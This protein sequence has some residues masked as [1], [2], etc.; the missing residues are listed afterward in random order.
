MNIQLKEKND[1]YIGV[2]FLFNKITR[3]AEHIEFT[4][5]LL[6]KEVY[7]KKAKNKLQRKLKNLLQN[8]PEL[9]GLSTVTELPSTQKASPSSHLENNM[10]F[11]RIRGNKIYFDFYYTDS[12]T[13]KR[14][15]C[16]NSTGFKNSREN[17]IKAQQLALEK[18]AALLQPNNPVPQNQQKI[19]SEKPKLIVSK[20][21]K[22]TGK[23][24]AEFVEYYLTTA[25]YHRLAKKSKQLYEMF[26][27]LYVLPEFGEIPL[28]LIDSDL[29][30][31]FELCLIDLE[32]SPKFIRDLLSFVR[33]L[34]RFA[35]KRKML[36]FCPQFDIISRV[37]ERKIKYLNDEQ[38]D[39]FVQHVQEQENHYFPILFFTLLT[40]VRMGEAR[41]VQWGDLTLEGATPKVKIQRS[42]DVDDTFKSTKTNCTREI[43][44][45]PNLVQVL[46]EL[47]QK[48]I[49]KGKE[50]IVF[51]SVNGKS[52]S[53]TTLHKVVVRAAK[54]IGVEKFSFHGLRHTFATHVTNQYGV[55]QASRMLGHSDIKTTMIYYQQDIRELSKIVEGL[56]IKIK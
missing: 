16:Q 41:S 1:Q 17:R 20:P 19:V 18:R 56:D 11:I 22:E 32:K 13:Q 2:I 6:A 42:M 46:L 28:H 39:A 51:L 7:K 9:I 23:T 25:K 55:A 4:S 38:R 14:K 10:E 24:M 35:V 53:K 31:T 26:L 50:D 21:E 40:G 15:R 44:L 37:G 3:Q 47:K 43:P 54:A 36:L 45:S 33:M 12:K 29:I 30:E 27:R 5:G 8:R 34:L 49:K 52:H 48:A